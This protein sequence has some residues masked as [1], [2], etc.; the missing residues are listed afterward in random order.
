M[1]AIKFVAE[2]PDQTETDGY[3]ANLRNEHWLN[4]G[5]VDNSTAV[6]PL[7]AAQAARKPAAKPKEEGGGRS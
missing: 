6:P 5:L 3:D 1:K 4:L 7:F 2:T